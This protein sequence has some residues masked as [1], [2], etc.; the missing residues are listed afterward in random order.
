MPQHLSSPSQMV[1]AAEQARF[2]EAGQES[3]RDRGEG[4]LHCPE[5]AG[6]VHG[7]AL[8]DKSLEQRPQ[9]EHAQE[10]EDKVA[11]NLDG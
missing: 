9:S 2:E 3:R 1:H 7:I 6:S 5:Y 11:R 4:D 10:V 8:K